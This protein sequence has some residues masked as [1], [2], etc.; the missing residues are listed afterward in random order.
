MD[1][2][3]TPIESEL[4]TL[5]KAEL[6]LA[7]AAE[8]VTERCELYRPPEKIDSEQERKDAIKNRASCRKDIAAIDAERKALLRDMEDALKQFKDEV[9]D[10]LQ[11][12]TEIDEE[13][14]AKLD[15]YEESW[16]VRRH[17]ELSQ[18]YGALAPALMVL[19][20]FEK[21]LS[22]FGQ[23]SGKVWLN[24]STNIVAVKNALA[25]AIDTIAD[26]ESTIERLVPEC[27]REETKALYFKTL[28]LQ[29]ALRAASELRE[30]RERV[31]EL[32][33]MR[34]EQEAAYDNPQPEVEEAEQPAYDNPQPEVEGYE[35]PAVQ[36][37]EPS[38]P[39]V[40]VIPS[41]T[42]EQMRDLAAILGQRGLSGNIYAGTIEQVYGRLNNA[43]G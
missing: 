37:A 14:K 8:R 42:T 30:Q 10:V 9:K 35:E 25:D 18:E 24:R 27:D 3:A 43:R 5:S 26:G 15:A 19:V 13:Y 29:E 17:I 4:G 7:G 31:R 36:P 34:S 21:V 28:D 12:L 20:P 2:E 33:R 16:K 1:V 32:E 22:K 6:W 39:F 40:V 38:R 23:E 11:P 41:A